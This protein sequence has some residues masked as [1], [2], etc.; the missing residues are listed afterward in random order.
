MAFQDLHRLW[1]HDEN[2]ASRFARYG[3]DAV[4][5][6]VEVI[7]LLQSVLADAHVAFHDEDLLAGGMAMRGKARARIEAEED[8]HG[9]GRGVTPKQ[10]HGDTGPALRRSPIVTRSGHRLLLVD[11]QRRLWCDRA[12]Y[13]GNKVAA[14]QQI[15]G[16]EDV[17]VKRHSVR[18][19]GAEFPVR[20]DVID[21]MAPTATGNFAED[22]Q[23]TFGAEWQEHRAILPEHVTEFA[24][25]FDLV[26]LRSLREARV[27]DLGCGSGRWSFF[28]KDH[29]RELVLVDFSDAIYVARENLRRANHCLFFKGDLLRLPFASNFADSIVCLGVLHHLPVPC[30]D[31]VKSLARFA[32]RLLIYLYYALDNR[33]VFF[34]ALLRMVD[35]ARA[36]LSRVRSPR[37][38]RAFALFGAVA[39]YRP[40][41]TLGHL[42]RPLGLGRHVPLYDVYRGK[43]TRRIQQDVYDRFFTRIEQ[44]V[45]R[46]QIEELRK[47]FTEVRVSEA[48][49]YWHF[50]I[51]R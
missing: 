38:R 41:I 12:V 32:P 9:A 18:V 40:L 36:N 3:M 44:R 22:V 25:Y 30:L 45:S 11:S 2:R 5:L 8:G 6:R 49:P 23:Y 26:D 20:D 15:F 29:C 24:Q 27:C 21:V 35:G 16:V 31:A 50:L 46:A 7:T 34:R 33:P 4:R 13:Y 28:L 43:S 48:L 42:L 47:D 10:L 14:L 39:V 19:G 17:E 1:Q 37:F 51:I